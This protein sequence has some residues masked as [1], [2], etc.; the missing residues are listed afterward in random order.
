MAANANQVANK[1]AQMAHMLA[2]LPQTPGT[3]SSYASMDYSSGGGYAFN[4]LYPTSSALGLVTPA[5]GQ[6]F[7]LV[8]PIRS[9]FD[10][11]HYAFTLTPGALNHTQD[12]ALLAAG[13]VSPISPF[14]AD[15]RFNHMATAANGGAAMDPTLYACPQLSGQA[16]DASMLFTNPMASNVYGFTS[17]MDGPKS[18]L[19]GAA[20]TAMYAPQDMHMPTAMLPY[21]SATPTTKGPMSCSAA[22]T[23]LSQMQTP[24]DTAN[25]VPHTGLALNH[26]GH[27]PLHG[28]AAKR[29]VSDGEAYWAG[30]ALQS[31][32]TKDMTS[33]KTPVRQ[34]VV[35]YQGVPTKDTFGPVPAT[36]LL[37]SAVSSKATKRAN[38]RPKEA[39]KVTQP[40]ATSSKVMTITLRS[41]QKAQGSAGHPTP[42]VD[43][44]KCST[45]P[46][47]SP[48]LK[49]K[50]SHNAKTPLVLSESIS[51]TAARERH[52]RGSGAMYAT[53]ASVPYLATAASQDN[54]EFGLH[55]PLTKRTKHQHTTPVTSLG[56]Q[57]SIPTLSLP[58]AHNAQSAVEQ[59]PDQLET[60]LQ[61]VHPLG[62]THTVDQTL[63]ATGSP[64]VRSIPR[65][66]NALGLHMSTPPK[67]AI[68]R[69]M[70][71]SPH[72]GSKGTSTLRNLKHKVAEQK[73]RDAM[74]DAFERLKKILPAQIM[75]A[76]DGRELARP[77]LLGRVVDYLENLT[78]EVQGLRR[79][80]PQYAIPDGLLDGF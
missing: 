25:S 80:H 1:E 29:T 70:R 68:N 69:T 24:S 76:D 30:L 19:N 57:T 67:Q 18:H 59:S 43:A 14:H 35:S 42:A 72:S 7:N 51:L 56:N 73:R 55:A 28:R 5:T 54:S 49:R 66:R 44:D 6:P 41:P 65:G 62:N 34:R 21:L 47:H 26:A 45:S 17:A 33:T 52:P 20:H 15:G 50:R 63:V 12:P 75:E 37:L 39:K 27:T 58:L 16:W 31:S 11:N 23:P 74:K 53:G 13:L 32:G 79:H 3:P 46:M 4:A 40:N 61:Q 36:S 2:S 22:Q 48:T 64:A 71:K 78:H 8:S 10:A 9:E 38:P 77:V 60:Q